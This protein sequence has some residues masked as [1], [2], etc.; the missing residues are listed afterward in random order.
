MTKAKKLYCDQSQIAQKLKTQTVT[1]SK[2]SNCDKTQKH[3]L[4]QNSITEKATKLKTKL[5][6]KLTNSICDKTQKLK[7]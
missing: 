4:H 3:K 2:I 5:V 1:K 6:T 7:L